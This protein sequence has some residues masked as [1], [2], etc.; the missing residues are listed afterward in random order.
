MR[1]DA[2]LRQLEN[3]RAPDRDHSDSTSILRDSSGADLIVLTQRQ[4]DTGKSRRE[5][6]VQERRLSSWDD[7]K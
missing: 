6:E 2:Y 4:A 5:M 3:Q 1:E 7:G